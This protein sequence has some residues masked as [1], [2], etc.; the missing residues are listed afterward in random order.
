MPSQIENCWIWNGYKDY[1]TGGDN[2]EDSRVTDALQFDKP[3]V[4]KE[5]TLNQWIEH[6]CWLF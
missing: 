1:G 2:K 4:K 5:G 6:N 3:A